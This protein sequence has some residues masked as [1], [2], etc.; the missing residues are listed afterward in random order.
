VKSE[1]V[2]PRALALLLDPGLSIAAY[3]EGLMDAFKA[4]VK[5]KLSPWK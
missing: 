2:T 1:D 5:G 4:E 3:V